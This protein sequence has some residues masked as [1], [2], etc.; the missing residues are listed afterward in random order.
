MILRALDPA[1]ELPLFDEAYHW[2]DRPKKHTR[3]NRMSFEEFAR[4]YPNKVVMGLF[5]ESLQAVYVFIETAPHVFEG[6]FTSRRDADVAQVFA[7]AK[8][9]V[10][11]FHSQGAVVTAEIVERNRPLR[12][13][14]EALGFTLENSPCQ[15]V[16]V[17]C[18][19]A[20]VKYISRMG[21][22]NQPTRPPTS[23]N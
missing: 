23:I 13:F 6:H 14:V 11:W 8:T 20:T 16:N 18:K 17:G 22:T 7:G 9:M 15:I 2:R 12:A 21:L 4:D 5:N 3:I 19:V 10:D 1:T